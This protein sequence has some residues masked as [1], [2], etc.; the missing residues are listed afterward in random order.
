MLK[1]YFE[2]RNR[3]EKCIRSWNV[4]RLAAWK[5]RWVN[6]S[7]VIVCARL[8]IQYGA[9]NCKKVYCFYRALWKDETSDEKHEEINKSSSSMF[10][11]YPKVFELL[12]LAIF[13]YEHSHGLFNTKIFYSDF[14][15]WSNWIIMV[16][17]CDC[18]IRS[19]IISSQRIPQSL[20]FIFLSQKS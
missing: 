9:G 17:Y 13:S 14:F 19:K 8:L 12:L 7:L 18:A 11:K 10:Q 6:P 3:I 20:F 5:N 16:G 1:N 4:S 2:G 15:G